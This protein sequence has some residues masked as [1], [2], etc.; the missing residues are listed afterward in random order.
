MRSLSP[1][2]DRP[3]PLRAGGVLLEK[4]RYRVRVAAG[5]EDLRAAQALRGLC[6]GTRGLDQDHLDQICQQVLIDDT[7]S[8]D[9]VGCFRL[10]L[11]TEGEAM[12]HSYSAQFYDVSGLDALAGAKLELGRFCIAPHHRD[13]DIMR[14]AWGAVTQIVD[15]QNVGFLFGCSSFAGIDP[16]PYLEAISLLRHRYLAPAEL[17]PAARA[18]LAHGFSDLLLQ[19]EDVQKPDL[20]KAQSQ[21]PPLLRG[22]LAMGGWVGDQL[23]IDH[24]LGTC[25]VFTGLRVADVP[26]RRQAQLRAVAIP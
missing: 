23:V 3:S 2:Q 17:R 24:E 6:F 11:L 4:G 20:K 9:L 25:H 18:A 14:L 8:G 10:L 13:P 19:R 12:G 1:L 22:Y 26:S 21:L 15:D 16:Q 7:A 5:Q